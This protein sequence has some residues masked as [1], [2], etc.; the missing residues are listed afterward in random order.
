MDFLISR[1]SLDS[2]KQWKLVYQFFHHV[3]NSKIER[4]D[5]L[6]LGMSYYNNRKNYMRVIYTWG[7]LSAQTC[8]TLCGLMEGSLSGSSVHGIFQAKILEWVVISSS[9]GSSKPRDQT[10][11]SCI[12]YLG[13]WIHYHLESPQVKNIYVQITKFWNW[14]KIST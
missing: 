7:T 10:W 11:I 14:T 1:K 2:P 4:S 6:F 8:A 13:R 12:S 3:G 5:T 9:R